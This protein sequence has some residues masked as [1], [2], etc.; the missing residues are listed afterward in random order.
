MKLS[1]NGSAK[2]PASRKRSEVKQSQEFTSPIHRKKK[3]LNRVKNRKGSQE[4]KAYSQC[5][6]SQDEA[7]AGT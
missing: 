4:S 7:L 2:F 5:K 1:T 3:S 6:A